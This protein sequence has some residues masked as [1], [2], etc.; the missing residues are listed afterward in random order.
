M[1]PESNLKKCSS[2][3][4]VKGYK[5]LNSIILD[6]Y[7]LN[8]CECEFKYIKMNFPLSLQQRLVLIGNSRAKIFH[9]AADITIQVF[10]AVSVD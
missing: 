6:K 7:F 3:L 10:R 4:S 8:F 1:I 9:T 2:R 5:K